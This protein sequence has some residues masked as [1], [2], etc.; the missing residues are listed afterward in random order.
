MPPPDEVKL[1]EG[2]AAQHRF[3]LSVN[4]NP[5]DTPPEN[6]PSSATAVTPRPPPEVAGSGPF[7]YAQLPYRNSRYKE[8][9]QALREKYDRIIAK[10]DEYHHDLEIATAKIKKLQAENDLLLDAMNL[11]ATHQPSMF[12]LLPPPLPPDAPSNDAP[13]D[14]DAFVG[15]STSA[16]APARGAP[17]PAP[18]KREWRG[19]RE[20]ERQQ[21]H[22]ERQQQQLRTRADKWTPAAHGA[23]APIAA[24]LHRVHRARHERS[25]ALSPAYL[26]PNCFFSCIFVYCFVSGKNTSG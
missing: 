7:L 15:T 1:L 13:M 20:R 19:Q 9:F 5:A 23:I 10:Q 17:A 16:C 3:R 18:R 25:R 2:S 26:V 14:L 4:V 21:W 11:A 24:A 22:A 12:G 8:K 6:G